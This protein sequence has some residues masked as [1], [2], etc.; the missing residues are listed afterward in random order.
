[1]TFQDDGPAS[2]FFQSLDDAECV[3]AGL[4]NEGVL[5]RGVFDGPGFEAGQGLFGHAVQDAGFERIAALQDGGG[6]AVGVDVET[7]GAARG[8][9]GAGRI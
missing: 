1:V 9:S 6:K 8:F 5:R 2:D 3:G 4:Y 7:D